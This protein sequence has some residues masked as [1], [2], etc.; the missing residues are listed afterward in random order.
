MDATFITI[1]LLC[2]AAIGAG[3]LRPATS[4]E[5]ELCW[6]C[7]QRNQHKLWCPNR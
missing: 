4:S 3:L 1:V 2:C 5:S 7:E 6:S